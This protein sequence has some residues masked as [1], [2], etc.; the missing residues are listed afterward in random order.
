M[1]ENADDQRQTALRTM[2]GELLEALRHREQE[3]LRYLTLLLPAVGGF[4]WLMT[5][6]R[7]ENLALF[8]VGTV[9]VI[10]L[11]FLGAKYA[12]ALGYNY[13]YLT[14]QLAKLEGELKIKDA[15]LKG[16]PRN[17]A[18]FLQRYGNQCYPPGIIKVFWVAFLVGIPLVTIIAVLMLVG[19]VVHALAVREANDVTLWKVF[20]GVGAAGLLSVVGTVCFVLA[21]TAPSRYGCKISQLLT[22]EPNEW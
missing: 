17:K 20:F 1:C 19:G 3:I 13:R 16:W 12:L 10:F 5:E 15:I 14:I 8:F 9:G 18:A 2:Q 21:L 22:D 11:L 6:E 4:M 7:K